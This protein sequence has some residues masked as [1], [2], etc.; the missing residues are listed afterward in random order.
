[1]S[2]KKETAWYEKAAGRR[3]H[4]AENTAKLAARQE[5]IKR[6]KEEKEAASKK[7]SASSL[8]A[9]KNRKAVLDRKTTSSKNTAIKPAQ[10]K[11]RCT[12]MFS[13]SAI[14]QDAQEIL[15]TFDQIVAQT[16][17]MS[18]KQQTL[19][20]GQIKKL[21]HQLTDDRSSRR[22]G[23]MNDASLVSAYI[24][25][26]M[27]WNLVRLTKLFANLPKEGICLNDGDVCLD[28]GSGP[29]TVPVALWLS[30]P[31]LRNKKLTFYCMDLSQT[32]LSAGE[33]IF[34]S[35]AA[36]TIKDNQE[37][38][39]IIRVKGA[40][41][42]GIKEKAKLVTCANVF[43]ELAQTNEMPPDYLSK[44][45][46]GDIE[47]YLSKDEG[48]AVMLIEPGDPKSARLVSLMRDSFIRRGLMPVSPCPHFHMCPMEGRTTSNP[49][50]KWCNFAFDT[51]DAPLQLLKL[52]EKSNL[53]KE[54]AV[55]SYVLSK[56]QEN[57]DTKQDDS[58]MMLR[59][60]SDFIKLPELRKSGYYCCSEYGLVL[61]IDQSNV[62][63]VNGDLIKV[64]KPANPD[65]LLRDKKSDALIIEI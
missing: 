61:A 45:Y 34:L 11:S 30:R 26:F 21:S 4:K 62:R 29:L 48:A 35:I 58:T 37:P 44:K 12:P 65:K 20:P 36:R 46:T 13:S 56:R 64:K 41:G 53:T 32:A 9:K 7:T 51:E 52:S 59:V 19:L 15:K 10:Q 42:T 14:P 2:E 31:E 25:Y 18:S 33:E 47:S 63:P 27:W 5:E 50:G 55:L 8:T 23:Y 3:Q 43:N 39:K 6:K 57:C 17:N 24:S 16:R 28:L 49:N 60:A 38:W 22:I 54:R 1:M 40:I